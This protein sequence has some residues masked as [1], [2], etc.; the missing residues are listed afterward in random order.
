MSTTQTR[1]DLEIQINIFVQSNQMYLG[2]LKIRLD[3]KRITRISLIGRI[4]FEVPHVSRELCTV[5]N[6][7]QIFL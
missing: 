1:D 3:A 2:D 4:T 7:N 6:I 5:L